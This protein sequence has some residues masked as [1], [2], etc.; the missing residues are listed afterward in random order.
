MSRLAAE[1]LDLNRIESIKL[2]TGPRRQS[3]VVGQRIPTATSGI[4]MNGPPVVQSA[5]KAG[6]HECEAR[7]HFRSGGGKPDIGAKLC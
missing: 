1:S 6:T 7:R 2:S 3:H 5:E 4:G